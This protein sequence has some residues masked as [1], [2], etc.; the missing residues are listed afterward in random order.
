MLSTPVYIGMLES[1]FFGDIFSAIYPQSKLGIPKTEES[2]MP[3][4]IVPLSDIQ[5]SKAKPKDKDY[6]LFD[7]GGLY[8]LVTTTGGK[9]WRMKYRFEGKERR[10]AFGSYPEISLADARRRKEEARKLVANGTDPANAKK[11][12]K[13]AGEDRA[14]NSFEVIA[15]EW[16]GAFQDQWTPG[17]ATKLLSR[18]ERELFP[19][20][21]SMPIEEIKAPDVLK[22]LKR[23]E[24][25]GILETAHRVKTI[26]SQVLRYA[27]AHGRRADRDCTADLRGAL[28]PARAKHFGALTDPKE[29]APLLRAIDSFQGSFVVKCAL[30]L[31]PMLFCRPG[32]L[33]GMEWAELDLDAAEWNI[34]VERM[35]LKNQTKQDRKGQFHLVPLSS[36]SVQILKELHPLTGHSKYVFPCHRTPLRPMSENAITAALRRLGYTGSEMTG[37]GFRATARTILDEVLGFR[38]DIIEHQLAHAVRDANGRAYNRTSFLKDRRQMMQQWADYLD[39][40]KAGAKVIPLRQ[41]K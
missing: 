36:Q 21:G 8:L 35:K 33:R 12:Q 5:V 19:Y 10:I 17:H 15:R 25:R 24:S 32:E 7:G 26:I 27:I 30:Q 18:M 37:H 14:A 13:Q 31:S 11:A 6:N 2:A 20:I 29:V 1:T 16:Y 4:R 3:K 9:L 28:P 38:P 22:V 34:P 23:I 41:A 39:G 40:L